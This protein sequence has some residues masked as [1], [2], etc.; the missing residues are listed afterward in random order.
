VLGSLAHVAHGRQRPKEALG[1]I[2][3]AI[4]TAR[5]SGAFDLVT[6]LNDTRKAWAS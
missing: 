3:Q 6:S 1:F 5:Q 4:E 2:D